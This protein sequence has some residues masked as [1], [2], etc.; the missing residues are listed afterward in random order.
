MKE[1]LDALVREHVGTNAKVNGSKVFRRKN[2]GAVGT[3]GPGPPG[4]ITFQANPLVVLFCALA[5]CEGFVSIWTASL[6]VLE[7]RQNNASPT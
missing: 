5:H 6:A 4:R 7:L 3:S 1:R 2:I